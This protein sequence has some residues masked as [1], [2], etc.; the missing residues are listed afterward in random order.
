M[1]L[2]TQKG[3]SL[4]GS[5]MHFEKPIDGRSSVLGSANFMLYLFLFEKL[6]LD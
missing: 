3:S 5:I 4:R 2:D 1:K 6:L